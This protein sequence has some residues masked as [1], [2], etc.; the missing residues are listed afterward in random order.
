MNQ[1]MT[2]V[3]YKLDMDSCSNKIKKKI[4]Q[5]SYGNYFLLQ[6]DKSCLCFDD[7]INSMYKSVVFSN[8]EKKILCF[9]PIKSIPKYVFTE[10]YPVIND[11]IMISQCID[12][13]MINL[14]YDHRIELWKIATKGGIG[15]NYV[16]C[17]NKNEP[18]NESKTE[19]VYDVF[20]DTLSA[21]KYETLNELEIIK[22]L[23][24][25]VS[26]TFILQHPKNTISK[27]VKTPHLYLIA[28]YL[29]KSDVNEVEY[30]P[31]TVYEKWDLFN[32]LN[33]II[34]FPKQYYTQQYESITNIDYG[35]DYIITN[36]RT[37][38]HC[39]IK[40]YYRYLLKKTIHIDSTI[41]YQYF[42]MRR[43]GKIKEYIQMFP[44]HKKAFY[45]IQDDY[46]YFI[47]TIHEL[48][49]LCYVYK[50]MNTEDIESIYFTHIYKL[51]HEVY[52]PSLSRKKTQKPQKIY[53]K[54]VR[55]YFD[56]MEPRELLFIMSSD[57]R[58]Y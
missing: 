27:P 30:I 33:G 1:K 46:E 36:I 35:I 41:Q 58:D 24:K 13:I 34:E 6:Y 53:R 40:S 11:E 23:P 17:N 2:S 50:S 38:E 31:P 49:C 4:I 18:K 28:V 22:L 51:H 48:Y 21:S 56:S 12:G 39:K 57:K 52:L 45:T 16:F 54:T 37:G 44:K 42:C 26:Y 8:P 47:S 9:S 29:I 10:R 3:T 25:N 15:G 20:L 5:K 14:F 19:S 7:N 32:D 43:I 55:K